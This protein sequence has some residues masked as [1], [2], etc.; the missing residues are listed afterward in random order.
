MFFFFQARNFFNGLRRFTLSFQAG[1]E[2]DNFGFGDLQ[3]FC[4]LRVVHSHDL[5]TGLAV[6][7][8]VRAFL[9]MSC[10]LASW[11]CRPARKGTL[12]FS[13]SVMSSWMVF[14]KFFISQSFAV[15]S[16]ILVDAP[17][18]SLKQ[19]LS[20]F[21]HHRLRLHHFHITLSAA[22]SIVLVHPSIL[23]ALGAL[24]LSTVGTLHRLEQGA[25]AGSAGKGLLHVGV[26]EHS[27]FHH[28]YQL[29]GLHNERFGDLGIEEFFTAHF[30]EH[31]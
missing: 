2:L 1:F 11:D 27:A 31:R 6:C 7:Y 9:K 10:T 22:T 28:V 20:L 21:F 13:H 18:F 19:Q 16:T 23:H 8:V 15:V 29:V 26:H 24:V 4:K 5:A 17:D 30:L 3:F 14:S 12:H 25:E